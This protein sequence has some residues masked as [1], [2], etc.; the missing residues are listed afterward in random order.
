MGV[1][2]VRHLVV[3]VSANVCA[4]VSMG[5]RQHPSTRTAHVESVGCHLPPARLRVGFEVAVALRVLPSTGSPKLGSQAEME[6]KRAN[7][8]TARAMWDVPG[9]CAERVP[10]AGIN[11]HRAG[12]VR[13]MCGGCAG[14]ARGWCGKRAVSMGGMRD[15]RGARAVILREPCG[16]CAG[17][18]REW[19]KP[20]AWNWWG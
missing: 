13:D 19:Y 3:D 16:T 7:T 1:L 11:G 9:K 20:C 4:K 18:V 17:V 14:I 15:E 10:C 8:G 5:R 2:R 6:A 12:T